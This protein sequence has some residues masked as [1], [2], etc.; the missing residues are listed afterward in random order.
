MLFRFDL[1]LHTVLESPIIQTKMKKKIFIPLVLCVIALPL[2]NYA[3][4]Q[5]PELG[6]YEKLDEFIPADL[7]Y[8][9]ENYDTVNLLSIIDKPT[10]LVPVYYNCPGICTPLLE[11]V[12]DVISKSDQVIGIDYQVFTFSFNY[13]ENTRLARDKKKT[14]S[15][16]V[17]GN[18][19]LDNGWIYFT[20][21]ST[22][23]HR[24]LNSIGYKIK[25]QGKEFIHPGAVVVLSP[26]GKITR[27]LHGTYF[28]P[29]DLKMAIVE[30]SEGKSG[31]TI[32]KFLKY[33]FSYDPEGQK[34]VFNVTKVSG[35]II[36]FFAV[37]LFLTLFLKK[38]RKKQTTNN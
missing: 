4:E 9:S 24:L 20:A 6:I 29:F 23:V 31:P 8:V 13:K 1:N 33:C 26:D 19:D 37:L 28:L 21:D 35:S 27:Y 17:K 2:I 22:N 32:N 34:Y 11:G 12:A 15:Q 3:Q 30:A 7:T 5:D 25:R 38:N 36:L 14:F 18:H 16:L 10:V